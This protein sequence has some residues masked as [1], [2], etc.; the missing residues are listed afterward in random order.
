MMKKIMLF[1]M[2]IFACFAMAGCGKDYSGTYVGEAI[3]DKEYSTFVFDIKKAKDN[4][5]TISQYEATYSPNSLEVINKDKAQYRA[6]G[7]LSW[8]DGPTEIPE[9]N[10]PRYGG[11][12]KFSYKLIAQLHVSEPDDKG[13]MTGTYTGGVG[14]M[15]CEF[16]IDKDGNIM[17]N[18][19]FSCLNYIQRSSRKFTK[20]KDFNKD[21]LKPELQER[22]TNYFKDRYERKD[23]HFD[24]VDFED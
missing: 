18:N 11:K 19:G 5:Y 21:S 20:V 15:P 23:Q 16:V 22:M 7:L 13:V 14:A 2:A 12:V 4:G 3:S 6:G 9:E 24:H 17:D 10:K 8:G 1:F